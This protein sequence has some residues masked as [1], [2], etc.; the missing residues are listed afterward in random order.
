MDETS[1]LEIAEFIA[2]HKFWAGF[3]LGLFV[4]FESLILIGA[5]VPATPLLFAAGGLIAASVLDPVSVIAWCVTGAAAGDA[6]S[7]SVGRGF[8]ARALLRTNFA[9]QR[10]RAIAR[11]RL[12]MRRFGAASIYFGRFLGPMRAF[13][14]AVA[15]TLRMQQRT[16]QLA[17]V[18]SAFVWVLVMLAPGYF[19]AKGFQQFVELDEIIVWVALIVALSMLGSMVAWRALN[20]SAGRRRARSAE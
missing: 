4:F 14:P 12:L 9:Q 8:G 2:R 17:N 16:F 6:I 5:F 15:G 1:F 19:G 11:A 13:V 7:Y 20:Q 18:G 3:V 10:K